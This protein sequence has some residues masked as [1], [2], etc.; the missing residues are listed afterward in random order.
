M[1]LLK[2]MKQ[3]LFFEGEL[4]KTTIHRNEALS[5]NHLRQSTL[6]HYDA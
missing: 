5:Q 6:I 4:T 2:L 1:E 3:Q